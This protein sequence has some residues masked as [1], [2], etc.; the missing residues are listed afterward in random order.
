MHQ[1]QR[2]CVARLSFPS[3]TDLSITKNIS[4]LPKNSLAVAKNWSEFFKF[5]RSKKSP[6]GYPLILDECMHAG[7]D[8]L[9][10]ALSDDKLTKYL[11]PDQKEHYYSFL[12]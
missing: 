8:I 5:V 1:N 6:V 2:V 4:Y 11:T 7:K 3:L 12:K 9:E 10:T